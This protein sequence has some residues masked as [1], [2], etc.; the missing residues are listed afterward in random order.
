MKYVVLASLFFIN[1]VFADMELSI[2]GLSGWSVKE[3]VVEI[4]GEPDDKE[5]FLASMY[6]E[7]YHYPGLTLYFTDDYLVNIVSDNADICTVQNICPSDSVDKAISAYGDPE[8]KSY[9]SY[10]YDQ[11][12]FYETMSHG[13]WYIAEVDGYNINE[14]SIYCH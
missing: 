8:I 3:G 13:C 2:G 12:N 9:D 4:K 6:T 1:P 7:A 5:E 14:I 10:S 11:Y